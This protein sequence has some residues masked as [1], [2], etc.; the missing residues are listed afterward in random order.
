MDCI[1]PGSS[2]HGT[3]A[4]ILERVTMPFSDPGTEPTSSPSLVGGFFTTSATWEARREGYCL[5][6]ACLTFV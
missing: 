3:L 4:R 2:V 1:P 6:I 5:F